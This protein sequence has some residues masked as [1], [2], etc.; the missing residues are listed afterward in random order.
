MLWPCFR[1]SQISQLP[2]NQILLSTS[3]CDMQNSEITCVSYKDKSGI[4]QQR[5]Q[6]SVSV[7]D[8]CVQLMLQTCLFHLY[9]RYFC[10]DIMKKR[11][12]TIEFM[13]SRSWPLVHG[14]K[15]KFNVVSVWLNTET[16]RIGWT[17]Y[18][19]SQSWKLLSYP[20]KSDQIKA[21]PISPYSWTLKSNVRDEDTP[22]SF[23][24]TNI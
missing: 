5:G 17:S 11:N 23:C 18:M 1:T 14:W 20:R 22:C 6:S 16:H 21:I 15:L 9:T 8:G 13:W 2:F 3:S 12:T 19:M 7:W 24:S 4:S 10:Q